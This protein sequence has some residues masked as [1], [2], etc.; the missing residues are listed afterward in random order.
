[1][2]N[3]SYRSSHGSNLIYQVVLSN[4][5]CTPDDNREVW[6]SSTRV[7]TK[8]SSNLCWGIGKLILQESLLADDLKHASILSYRLA[9]GVLPSL[10]S[11]ILTFSPTPA[12]QPIIPSMSI[13]RPDFT[14]ISW[15][16]MT[17]S[18]QIEADGRSPMPVSMMHQTNLYVGRTYISLDDLEAEEMGINAQTD[19][20]RRPGLPA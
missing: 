15:N 6:H 7:P 2:S 16:F 19:S 3:V 14:S 9:T 13:S 4:D 17:S 10:L 1:M 11:A 8:L 20:G 18:K 5:A 12:K